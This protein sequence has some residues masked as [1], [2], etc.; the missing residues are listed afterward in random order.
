MRLI[1]TIK[2]TD[3]KC[4]NLEYHC[5]RAGF[6]IDEPTVSEEFSQGVVKW[7]VV[8]GDGLEIQSMMSHYKMPLITSLRLI[9]GTGLDYSRKYENRSDIDNLWHLRDGC[10]DILIVCDGMISDTSFCNVVFENE[11]GLFTPSTPLLCGT[12][13]QMLL[14]MGVISQRNITVSDIKDFSSVRLINAMIELEDNVT[15]TTVNIIP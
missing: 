3:G 1:E 8:Y 14:D 7:R 13:R 11:Y 5:R 10:D 12:K 6:V 9:D 4:R 2:L 15:I